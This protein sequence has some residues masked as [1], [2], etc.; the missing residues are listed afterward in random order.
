MNLFAGYAPHS[1]PVKCANV[2]TR[3][4]HVYSGKRAVG[5]SA[6]RFIVRTSWLPAP[7][8]SVT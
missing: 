7:G 3:R 6:Y 5:V 2:T 1:E 8:A 4:C